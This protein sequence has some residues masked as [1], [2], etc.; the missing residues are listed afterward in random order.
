MLNQYALRCIAHLTCTFHV[1][2]AKTF[3]ML[4]A[5]LVGTV[6]EFV[7]ALSL[8]ASVTDTIA[9]S[10]ARTSAFTS[11]PG[12]WDKEGAPTHGIQNHLK[13]NVSM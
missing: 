2:G 7:G 12:G 6:F 9:G 4:Q 1:V 13:G 8:G 3:T 11:Y 5:C 10:I